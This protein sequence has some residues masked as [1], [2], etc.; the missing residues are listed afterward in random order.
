M[1]VAAGQL[2]RQLG[3]SSFSVAAFAVDGA[4]LWRRTWSGTAGFPPDTAAAVAVDRA[5][6]SIYAVGTINNTSTAT[7]MFAVGLTFNGSDILPPVIA[8]P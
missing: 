7:D 1:V 3:Q 8:L 4:E 6:G 5:R 2:S